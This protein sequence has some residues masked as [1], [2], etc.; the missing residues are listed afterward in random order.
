MFKLV[1]T[2]FLLIAALDQCQARSVVAEE[3]PLTSIKD[4][5]LP[6]TDPKVRQVTHFAVN[7]YNLK[8]TDKYASKMT[9][10]K[11]AK[12]AKD[13]FY[14]VTFDLARTNCVKPV[15]SLDFCTPDPKTPVKHCQNVIV[16]VRD[17]KEQSM[18]VTS[19]AN[20]QP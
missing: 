16:W 10:I 14:S 4:G 9:V 8:N 2:C 19:F 18:Q 1:V 20:C 17:Y 5:P 7:Q 15:P 6:V 11:A 3:A 13:E 12:V